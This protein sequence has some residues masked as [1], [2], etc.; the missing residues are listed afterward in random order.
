MRVWQLL[1]LST[2]N[3]G[4]E[5]EVLVV[6]VRDD[7]EHRHHRQP[8]LGSRYPVQP[9]YIMYLAHF[10]VWGLVKTPILGI[11]VD[12][13]DLKSKRHIYWQSLCD[14][15]HLAAIVGRLDSV[16]GAIV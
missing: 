8:V 11:V 13:L 16:L 14:Q 3:E 4:S 6:V 5:D 7:E 12:K 10:V 1:L 15:S 2:D 9:R